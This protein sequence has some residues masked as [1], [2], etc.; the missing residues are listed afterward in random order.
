MLVSTQGGLIA[1][2]DGAV[3]IRFP[4]SAFAQ[5]TAAR[6]TPLTGQTLPAL[7]PLG[8][9]PLQAFCL[10]TER[11]PVMPGTAVMVPWEGI[12]ASEPVV[13]ACWEPGSF[14]WVVQAIASGQGNNALT[15]SL[16]GSGT[17]V[18]VVA[19]R[20]PMAPPAPS[21]GQPLPGVA[22]PSIDPAQLTA[23]GVVDPPSS[24]A[25]QIPARV[26]A[27]ARVAIASS[28]GGLPSGVRLRGQVREEYRLRDGSRR[29]PPGY[30][31]SIVAYQRPGDLDPGTLHAQFPMRPLLLFGG[32]E[33]AEAVVR[34]DLLAP[35]S[36]VGAILEPGGG[37]IAGEGLRLIA[38]GDTFARPQAAQFRNLDPADFTEL[39]D[40]SGAIVIQASS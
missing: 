27:T 31:Q 32:E 22:F 17:C 11:E 28:A 35:T 2:G 3:E 12:A 40:G 33:L 6:L 8:W 29:F 26:T 19:D 4:A 24:S 5:D 38:A 37:E 36:F 30:E 23:T 10:E 39:V 1:S 9:S 7:L 15:F 25:S 21:L 20:A 14:G 34:V 13:L 18:L 16:D